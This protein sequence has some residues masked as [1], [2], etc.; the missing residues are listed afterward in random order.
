MRHFI[1]FIIIG[2]SLTFSS[3]AACAKEWRGI[4]PLYSTRADV[5][6]LIGKPDPKTNQY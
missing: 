3:S 4:V 5:E 2:F 1:S 6:P